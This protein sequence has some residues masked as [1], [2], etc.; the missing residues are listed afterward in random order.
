MASPETEKK[1]GKTNYTRLTKTGYYWRVIKQHGYQRRLLL[2][3]LIITVTRQR[4]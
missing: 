3:R 2:N 1:N 4:R